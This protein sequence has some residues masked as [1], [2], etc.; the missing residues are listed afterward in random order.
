MNTTAT[1]KRHQSDTKIV[2]H[3]TTINSTTKSGNSINA[4][5]KKVQDVSKLEFVRL[6]IPRLIP[7]A[8]IEAVKGRTFTPEQFIAYQERNIDSP[9]N[10]LYALID[11]DK[12][13]QGVLWIEMNTLDNSLFV[14][15]FSIAK[16]YWGKG[17]GIQKVIEFVDK[18]KEKMKASRVFWM[19]V[20]EKFYSK[21]GFRR[22]KNCLMEYNSK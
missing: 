14:T 20:N 6:K 3:D 10:F 21:H 16:V 13:I 1:P 12:K 15:M 11:L 2:S 19:T 5:E 22:S 17:A 7:V 18:L 8:L 9:N 4:P